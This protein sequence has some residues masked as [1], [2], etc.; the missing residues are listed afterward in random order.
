[1]TWQLSPAASMTS[2]LCFTQLSWSVGEQQSYPQSSSIS[3]ELGCASPKTDSQEIELSVEL[4]CW[5]SLLQ[6]TQRLAQ[7]RISL[8]LGL[9]L[10][11]TAGTGALI[12]DQ[13]R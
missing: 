13:G 9:L 2:L 11:L 5:G 12:S 1:M 4:R 7:E 6:D 3:Q 8:W 10:S